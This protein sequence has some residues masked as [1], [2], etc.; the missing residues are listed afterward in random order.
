MTL[1]AGNNTIKG[2]VNEEM[3]AEF[4]LKMGKALGKFYGSPVAVAIDGRNT[5]M[6]L[7]SAL[8]AGI[9]SVGCDVVDLG[10][11][12]T[13]LIQFYMVLHPEIKA[14]VTITASF[15]GL[16]INGFRVM[17]S[18]G[19][20]DPIFEEHSIEEILANNTQV[21][22]LD[23]GEVRVVTDFT[24]K[25]VDYILSEVDEEA[26][27]KSNLKICLDCRNKVVANIVSN[28][29]M[30]LSIE[31]LTIGGDSSVVDEARM[32]KLGHV[33]KGQGMDLGVALEM[34]ADHCL[35]TTAEGTPV[36]GDKVF[37]LLA[38]SILSFNKGSVVMPL[39][40][41]TL[42]EDVVKESGGQVRYCDIGE[43]SVVR[44]VKESG[45][46]FGGDIFGCIVIP[47]PFCTCDAIEGMVRVLEIVAKKGSL[48][49]L[50][51]P[52]PDYHIARASME[53]PDERFPELLGKYKATVAGTKTD[54]TKGVKVLREGGWIIVRH[55]NVKGVVKVYT[56]ADS[57]EAADAWARETVDQ[58]SKL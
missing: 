3:D 46:V 10:M 1:I 24:E 15:S 45:A 13:P 14:G 6:M 21:P 7:K 26:I 33:V 48:A 27:R 32:I 42:M 11:I 51:G 54:V 39:N 34:D 9:M 52:F 8:T 22:G 56:Q 38:Q 43:Q 5:N 20:E 23:V 2:T 19:I 41:S 30:R 17:K 37:A 18:T 53:Y 16:D 44:Y 57:L 47:G 58:L 25:Y 29:L 50:I 31:C 49:Q 36:Q 35:F 12:P 4:A 28:I 40:S 55:S